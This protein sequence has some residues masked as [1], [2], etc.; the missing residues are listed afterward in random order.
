MCEDYRA[1]LM[2]S[3]ELATWCNQSPT[4]AHEP[5]SNAQLKHITQATTQA[6]QG[7]PRLRVLVSCVRSGP[8][9][10]AVQTAPTDT[11]KR[12]IAARSGV[13]GLLIVSSLS[14]P[15]VTARSSRRW[16][17]AA[18]PLRRHL[19]LDRARGGVREG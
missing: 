3:L 13:L 2:P 14:S 1:Q 7:V 9:E 16:T 5:E 18:R 12:G 8:P 4:Q 10:R 6:T 19:V 17:S 15:L 11:S